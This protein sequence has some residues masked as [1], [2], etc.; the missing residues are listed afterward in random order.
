MLSN[1]PTSIVLHTKRHHKGPRVY[2]SKFME[3]IQHAPISI[4]FSTAESLQIKENMSFKEALHIVVDAMID[5]HDDNNG[6]R[7]PHDIDSNESN[8]F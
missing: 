4:L 2:T 6:K 1:K 3:R 7:W 8:S 5:Q